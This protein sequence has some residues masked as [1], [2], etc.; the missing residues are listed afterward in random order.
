M[1]K[2]NQPDECS[3]CGVEPNSGHD[4]TCPRY[5][6]QVARGEYERLFDLMEV[7][8]D[9]DRCKHGR[10]HLDPCYGCP[11][12]LSQGNQ[13]M[14]VG[15]RIGT[16]INGR[17]LVMPSRGHK[18]DPKAYDGT[19]D[20][21]WVDPAD[22]AP[23]NPAAEPCP[24]EIFDITAVVNRVTSRKDGPVIYY[25]ADIRVSCVCG[26]LFEWVGVRAG[27]SPS[28]PCVSVDSIELRAPIRP[29]GTSQTTT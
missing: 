9:L 4:A 1:N 13:F 15:S 19:V 5:P 29:S 8:M 22:R 3:G 21:K 24:H 7:F 11:G 16:G 18:R 6:I 14:P 17:P 12:D 25:S 2:S 20:A 27:L 26:E 28:H 10:H 23:T